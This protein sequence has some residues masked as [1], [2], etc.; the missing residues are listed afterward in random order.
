[1]PTFTPKSCGSFLEGWE[2][3]VTTAA[4]LVSTRHASTRDR[5]LPQNT[6]TRCC[7][8]QIGSCQRAS[9]FKVKQS[10]R[11][12]SKCGQ[13]LPWQHGVIAQHRCEHLKCSSA[14]LLSFVHTD[15]Y[16][17]DHKITDPVDKNTLVGAACLHSLYVEDKNNRLYVYFSSE[18]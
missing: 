18:F 7:A 13:I 14:V 16:G 1:V 17:S 6:W 5:A 2:L 10:I 8:V 11:N 12:P 4:A 15:N 9:T 3:P